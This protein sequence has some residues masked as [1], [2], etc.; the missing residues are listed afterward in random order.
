M[1]EIKFKLLKVPCD[2]MV[3]ILEEEFLLD[4]DGEF[5]SS[6]KDKKKKSFCLISGISNVKYLVEFGDECVTLFELE[7]VDYINR[8][9]VFDQID[10]VTIEK[11]NK[12]IKK[13]LEEDKT[14]EDINILDQFLSDYALEFFS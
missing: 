10:Q 8:K 9:L 14:S 11:A 2:I 7:S 6:I 12:K 13:F 3:P 5:L 4:E 1:K